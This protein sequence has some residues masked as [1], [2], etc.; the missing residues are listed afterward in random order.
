M[1]DKERNEK[2]P[3]DYDEERETGNPRRV[4][5]MWD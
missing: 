4:P 5:S 3:A 2:S 1:Q